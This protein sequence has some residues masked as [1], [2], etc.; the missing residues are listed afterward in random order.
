MG[1]LLQSPKIC[2]LDELQDYIQN[3]P[4]LES[5][6]ITIEGVHVRDVF[7]MLQLLNCKP[8][9]RFENSDCIL[10]EGRRFAMCLENLEFLL[11][12]LIEGTGADVRAA[13]NALLLEAV[14]FRS[15]MRENPGFRSLVLFADSIVKVGQR[16][17]QAVSEEEDASS[18]VEPEDAA[19][20][21]HGHGVGDGD[22]DEDGPDGQEGDGEHEAVQIGSLLGALRETKAALKRLPEVRIV[23]NSETT[24]N[25]SYSDFPGGVFAYHINP[26]SSGCASNTEEPP[27]APE[28][29]APTD[30]P[31][32]PPAAAESTEPPAAAE[33]AA[34]T[35]HPDE[36]PAAA[37][38][39]EPPAA[40]AL[41]TA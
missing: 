34:P 30:N 24:T 1:R 7:D 39:T 15:L 8:D 35:D 36:P 29:A 20:G 17:V 5:A 3:H 16:S 14:K 4:S 37:E 23:F 31:D 38:S 12:Q 9:W 41:P 21:Q 40:A 28:S 11:D 19:D 6:C 10:A 18:A 27:A 22:E 33:S 13:A 2:S 26:G 32:K 25:L